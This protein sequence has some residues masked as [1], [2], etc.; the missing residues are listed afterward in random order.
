MSL[1]YASFISGSG[2]T[3]AAMAHFYKPALV[4]ASRPDIDGIKKAQKLGIPVVVINPKSFKSN[5]EFGQAILKN[6]RKY[7]INYIIQNGWLPLTPVKVVKAF[8]NRI[9]NQHPGPLPR[10]GGRG[11]YGIHVHEA[12]I[13][14]G[15]NYTYAVAHRVTAGFDEGRVVKISPKIYFD[16]KITPEKLQQ[17]VLPYEHRLQIDLLK[18]IFQRRVI[19]L[20]TVAVIDA[21]GR[22]AALVEAYARSPQVGR[23]IAIPGN[24]LMSI[25]TDK[26]VEIYP[27][28]KT[29]DVKGIIEICRREKVDLVD[30]AQDNAVAI[31]LVD[32]LIRNK[33]NV[34]GPTKA[35]SRIEWDKAYCR[36]FCQK[37][38][39][40]QPEFKVFHSP[41]AGIEFLKKQK[42]QSWFIK[43]SGLAGG[44]GA[45][46]AKNNWEAQKAVL[47][48]KRFG[49]AG[50]TYL[51]EKWLGD[52]NQPAEEFSI[53]VFTD[54]KNYQIA[55]SAQDHKRALDGDKGENTGGMG[56]SSP[57]LLIT[58][59]FLKK[60]K[61]K[62]LDKIIKNLK[63]YQGVLYLGGIAIKEDGQL[64]PYVVEFNA[65]WG[66]PE[67]E[68]ILPGLKTDLFAISRAILK[69]KLNNLKIKTDSRYRVAV[70]VAAKGYPDDY[71][72]VKGK[73]IIGLDMVKNVKIYGAGVKVMNNKF[74][75]AGGRL[76]YVVGE[77]KNVLAARKRAYTALAK[78][79]I[80]G[81]NLYYRTDIGWRDVYRLKNKFHAKN[82]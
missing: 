81:N 23:L 25:N 21:G 71:S 7:K 3:M 66:D 42:D 78:I 39:I 22:G 79:A 55:G 17:L 40:P 30:V 52:S 12:V 26:P 19:D 75:A 64:N 48:L 27:E 8:K 77:G 76:F 2:T 14:S 68:V 9:F 74:Y 54:G 49:A 80:E 65:R 53:F 28:L 51:I 61:T 34:V 67:A 59:Q 18:D 82:S 70:T 1:K 36:R 11:M 33:I 5:N 63:N 44:K 56:C 20:Q 62:I 31:G 6:L 13:Q 57:P 69:R 35:A 60:V 4:I 45:L 29:T 24:D 46:P 72:A 15:R 41:Q 32:E 47:D 16:S 10:F 58:P 50:K 37:L 43:A 73:E 38:K